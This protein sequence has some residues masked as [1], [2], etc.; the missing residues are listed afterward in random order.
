MWSAPEAR[1]RRPV[2]PVGAFRP[3]QLTEGQRT[4]YRPSAQMARDSGNRVPLLAQV[5]RDSGTPDLLPF[6]KA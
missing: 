6:V 4:A 1:E 3:A 2:L 5:A